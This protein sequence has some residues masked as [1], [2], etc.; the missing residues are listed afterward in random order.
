[1]EFGSDTS[2]LNTT[3]SKQGNFVNPGEKLRDLL[4]GMLRFNPANDTSVF[5]Q[6][7]EMMK[8]NGELALLTYSSLMNY[9]TRRLI[10]VAEYLKRKYNGDD[11]PSGH[12]IEKIRDYLKDHTKIPSDQQ[13][14][15]LAL[16][17]ECLTARSRRVR[18]KVKER[19]R[20][21]A[22][23]KGLRCYICGCDMDFSLND[24]YRAAVIEHV[25]PN[26]MGGASEET[27][28]RVSCKKCSEHK[29]SY[30]DSSDF[31]FEEICLVDEEGSDDFDRKLN[32]QFKIAIWAKSNYACV[33]CGKPASSGSLGFARRDFDDNWHFLNMDAYCDEHLAQIRSLREKLSSS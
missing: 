1:M 30:M 18:P 16:L 32:R 8:A 22:Q 2:N 9:I 7:D 27:N 3:M 23:E 19:M 15:V 24:K 4:S 33:L 14:K 21:Q 11:Y 13:E 12:Y 25:W 10:T 26:A 28:L 20:R 31:H 6:I 17:L 5:A 29:Q